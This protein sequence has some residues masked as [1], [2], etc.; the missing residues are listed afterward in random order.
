[1]RRYIEAISG[2]LE[3]H[4]VCPDLGAELRLDDFV[5]KG[6][7]LI[8]ALALALPPEYHHKS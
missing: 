6:T 8:R 7:P 3:I 4:A 1:M 5:S 2:Q